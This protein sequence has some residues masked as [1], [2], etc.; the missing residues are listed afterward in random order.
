MFASRLVS[1]V[2]RARRR[3]WSEW[4]LFLAALGAAAGMWAALRLVSF[5]RLVTWTARPAD[6]ALPNDD[7]AVQRVLWAVAAARRRLFRTRPCLP[8]ALAARYL[9]ARR[10]VATV[11][12]IGVTR[13]PGGLDAHAWLERHGE[14][15]IGGR[16][17]GVHYR[18]LDT[19]SSVPSPH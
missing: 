9:L 4:G 6:A 11:L 8:T 14:V 17:A 18:P 2:H 3:S 1:V 19:S 13:A 16:D 7:P 15:L 10:G 5:R 12:R